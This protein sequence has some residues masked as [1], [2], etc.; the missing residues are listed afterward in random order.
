MAVILESIVIGFAGGAVVVGFRLALSRADILRQVVYQTL[1]VKTW[2][3]TVAWAVGLCAL[4]LFLGWCVKAFPMIKGSGIPQ[5]KGALAR[6][7]VFNWEPELF[8]KIVTGVIGIGAGLSLGRE[9]PSIQIAV[10]VGLGIL[11]LFKRPHAERKFLITAAS[12]AGLSA[13]F[14]APLAGVLFVLEELQ[15]SFSPLLIACAMG[16]SMAADAVAGL[17]F[18]FTP[19]FDFR[20]IDATPLGDFPWVVVLGIACALFGDIFKRLLYF[21][22]DFFQKLRISQI[23]RPI[24]PLLVTIPLGFYFFEVTG[25]GHELIEMLSVKTF[26]L[27]TLS[28]L[29]ILKLSFTAFCY[30][31]GTAGGIFLP[32]LACGAILGGIIG[33]ALGMFGLIEAGHNLNFMILGMAAF[34]SAVVKSPVTGIVLILEMSGNFNHLGSLVLVSLSAFVTSDII[35]SRPVYSVLL[36]RLL[37]RKLS[38]KEVKTR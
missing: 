5:I 1:A 13:A 8:L 23:F 38:T 29:F 6:Q 25:G 9:G 37:A 31:S 27:Q 11:H 3:W 10:Y 18:G 21:A 34:F 24:L 14:S 16:A 15:V 35:A 20:R 22:Q 28:V 19:V 4:G 7:V 36:E 12:A 33:Q 30:G 26:S 32:L 17:F 2:Y